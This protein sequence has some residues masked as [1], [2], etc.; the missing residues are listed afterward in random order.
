[1]TQA[2]WGSAGAELVE[3][4][5]RDGFVALP[6]AVPPAVVEDC[7]REIDDLL[8]AE[9]VDPDDR[10]TWTSPVVRLA[11]PTT[12]A[13]AS[14]GTQPVLWSFYDVLLGPGRW[15]RRQTVGGSIPVRFPHPDDPGDAGWHIDGSFAVNGE[16]WVNYASRARGLLCLFL[17]SDV[18]ADDAPTEIKVGS[19]M[20]IPPLLVDFG[21]A[22]TSFQNVPMTQTT[23]ERPSA[24]AT[25]NAGDVYVCHPFLVH[26]ATWPHRGI[27]PRAIAQPEIGL[28]KDFDV[29][30][31][32]GCPVHQSIRTALGH[33]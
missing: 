10:T 12:D 9:G 16:F 20:D 4:F 26:R 18:G 11:C 8:R 21:E 6:G 27:T 13:F 5:I 7:R 22:G 25:G 19:H 31:A 1:M 29:R 3:S 14:A 2:E 23:L 32:D 15:V 30:R 17:F 24:W 28:M 33:R